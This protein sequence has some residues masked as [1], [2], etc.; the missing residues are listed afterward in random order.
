MHPSIDVRVYVCACNHLGDN[1]VFLLK[2]K[3]NSIYVCM[4]NT[5]IDEL[6]WLTHKKLP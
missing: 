4:N 5:N 3:C 6:H 1:F 2:S